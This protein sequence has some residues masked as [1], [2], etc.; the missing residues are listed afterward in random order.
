MQSCEKDQAIQEI[1][2]AGVQFIIQEADIDFK[3]TDETPKCE[4]LSMDYAVFDFADETYISPI[5]FADGKYLTNTVKLD[6]G[7]FYSL[8]S[9]SVYHDYLPIGK[10][11]EDV[12]IKTSPA[13]GSPYADLMENPLIIDIEVETS[14]KKEVDVE[15]LCYDSLFEKELGMGSFEIKKVT[16][17]RQCFFGDV[18]LTDDLRDAFIG[19]DYEMQENGLQMDMPA[20]MKIMVYKDG[21]LVNTFSNKEYFGEGKCLEVFW[22]NNEDKEES[23]TFE[24]YVYYPNSAGEM[25]L[26]LIDTF[27]FKDAQGVN[28]N[29]PNYKSDDGVVD[30]VIGNCTLS[31]ADYS[32]DLLK[33]NE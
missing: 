21:E 10:G 4:D 19:S 26:V 2:E 25:D 31:A 20:I 7:G 12:L 17:E 16:I 8:T 18:C 6:F 30:F 3:N 13:D 29:V 1:P 23:F 32:Y 14:K 28:S 22:E 5:I 24:L 15:V 9:F 27:D 11:P 33:N